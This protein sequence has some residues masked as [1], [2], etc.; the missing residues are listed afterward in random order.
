MLHHQHT[1]LRE[2]CGG[3]TIKVPSSLCLAQQYL[4]T[5]AAPTALLLAE[6]L[7]SPC[8]VLLKL[9]SRLHLPNNHRA[10]ALCPRWARSWPEPS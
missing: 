10:G 4:P 8:R 3:V 2:N 5:Q 6:P 7:R 9:S 1:L